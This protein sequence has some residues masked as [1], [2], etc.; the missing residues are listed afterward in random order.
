MEVQCLTGCVQVFFSDD[1]RTSTVVAE[2]NGK[3]VT[4]DEFVNT[5]VLS[6]IPAAQRNALID[7]ED[8]FFQSANTV[9]VCP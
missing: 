2:A 7:T 4:T 1:Q 5:R 9:R 3:L 6:Q 8:S